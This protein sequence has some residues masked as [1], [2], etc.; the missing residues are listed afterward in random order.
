[1]KKTKLI[2]YSLL[3]LV[4]IFVFEAIAKRLDSEWGNNPI[5][6]LSG[7]YIA[8]VFF[9]GYE[10]YSWKSNLSEFLKRVFISIPFAILFSILA[11]VLGYDIYQSLLAGMFISILLLLKAPNWKKHFA[12][13]LIASCAF[14]ISAKFYFAPLD[15]SQEISFPKQGLIFWGFMLTL[16]FFL[17][18]ISKV[19]NTFK[20]DLKAILIRSVKFSITVSLFFAAFLI[21]NDFSDKQGISLSIQILA[22]SLLSICFL[23][24]CYIFDLSLIERKKKKNRISELRNELND[25]YLEKRAKIKK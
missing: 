11:K 15:E 9:L 14:I 23:V 3:L 8:I 2:V 12:A 17:L 19:L 20:P 10:L 7:M 18:Y 6:R 22:N 4:T 13:I 25:F 16:S 1:M 5:E 21:L 24:I